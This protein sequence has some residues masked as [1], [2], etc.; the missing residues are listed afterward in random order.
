MEVDKNT[1]LKQPID[2]YQKYAHN[3][4]YAVLAHQETSQ[5]DVLNLKQLNENNDADISEIDEHTGSK[6]ERE[7]KN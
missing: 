6:I 2:D 1:L 5:N 4:P 3:N 7:K